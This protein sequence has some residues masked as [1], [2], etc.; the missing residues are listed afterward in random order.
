MNILAFGQRTGV[1]LLLLVC[2][3]AC[4]SLSSNQEAQ[5]EPNPDP[6]EGM[7]RHMDKFNEVADRIITKPAARMY[8]KIIPSPIRNSLGRVYANL[9]DLNDAVNNLLQGKPRESLGDLTR[10][11]VNTTLGLGGL[12]DPASKMGLQDHDEDFGQTLASWG[13]PAGP[14]MVLPLLGPSTLRAS[15]V[16]PMDGLLD[17]LI[18]L[19]PVRHRNRTYGIRLVHQRSQFINL[20]KAIFGDRYLFIRD[21]YLQR[22]T[23]LIKDGEVE[24]PFGDDF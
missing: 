22:R 10:I 1:G 18:Y 14:Y 8:R 15:L 16:R 3:Q 9:R 13:M 19:H 6:W 12:F 5:T 7:N 17:P 4:A 24:D 11:T 21:A 2:L 23:Y 20:E